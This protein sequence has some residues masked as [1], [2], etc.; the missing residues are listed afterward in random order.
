LEVVN[1]KLQI[2]IPDPVTEA[3]EISENIPMKEMRKKMGKKPE[4]IRVAIQGFGNAGG[5]AAKILAK[6]GF[7]IIGASDSQGAIVCSKGLDPESLMV[8]KMDKK[9][10][11]YCVPHL[12]K[13]SAIGECCKE[14]TGPG[15]LEEE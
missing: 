7:K 2:K 13:H 6:Q 12:Q 3:E 14:V 4:E 5:Y 1:G 9:S 10:V 15:I 11:R 8:C